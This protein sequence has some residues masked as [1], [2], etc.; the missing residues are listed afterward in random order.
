MSQDKN[1]A[2]D[3]KETAKEIYNNVSEVLTE[4]V[5]RPMYFYF[6]ISWSII[7]WKF[8]YV[9]LFADEK[10]IVEQKSILKVE[11]LSNLY[12]WSSWQEA[13]YSLLFLVVLPAISAYLVVWWLSLLSE[14]FVK[15]NEEHK[16]RIKSVKK[17]ILE[18]EKFY[19]ENEM[20]QLR[21]IE[22][23]KQQIK[24]EDNSEYND[25][26]DGL[27]DNITIGNITILPSR[28]LYENDYGAYKV[29]LDEFKD[30][31]E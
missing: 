15:K 19:F 2:D 31:D 10:I 24:Y 9:F 7:N 28:A 20:V 17:L 21:E 14:K 23:K 3:I 27:Q 16:E 26:L 29:G 4:R 12:Q 1:T 30:S 13:S 25:Y 22:S 11:Y 18:K 6:I 8:L 5:F